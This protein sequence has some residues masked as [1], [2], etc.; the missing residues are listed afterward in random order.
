MG[1]A[2]QNLD[3]LVQ[4]PMGCGEQNMV[5]LL[6]CGLHLLS[7]CLAQSYSPAPK[8]SMCEVDLVKCGAQPG[9]QHFPLSPL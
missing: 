5:L 1:T 3:N 4:M 9:P 7:Q 6:G 2:L 8:A